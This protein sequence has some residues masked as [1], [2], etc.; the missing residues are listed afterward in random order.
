MHRSSC[1]PVTSG[2]SVLNLYGC[3]PW[4]DAQEKI[5]AWR[6]EYNESQPH[7]AF[8]NLSSN[9]NAVLKVA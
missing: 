6:Q 5:K 1:L 2:M 7:R 8:N 3:L 9:G 4:E